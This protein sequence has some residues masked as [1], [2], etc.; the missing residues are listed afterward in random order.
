MEPLTL[1]KLGNNEMGRV[2]VKDMLYL[3]QVG[4][5]G[6][7]VFLRFLRCHSVFRLPSVSLV[8]LLY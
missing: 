8:P 3:Q 2:E 7:L 5:G 1:S 4:E 6:I